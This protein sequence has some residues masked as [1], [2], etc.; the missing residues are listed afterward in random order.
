MQITKPIGTHNFKKRSGYSYVIQ[1][2]K[3]SHC[4]LGQA[5]FTWLHKKQTK[6][7]TV[8]LQDEGLG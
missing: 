7:K 8:I 6:I 2:R 5:I 4:H 3:Y 1:S